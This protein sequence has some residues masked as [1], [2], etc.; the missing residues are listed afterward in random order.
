MKKAVVF[1]GQFP[2]KL[3]GH[4][5]L[6]IGVKFESFFQY[7]NI[8]QF[9]HCIIN[10]KLFYFGKGG[11]QTIILLLDYFSVMNVQ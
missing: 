1:V 7:G 11:R 8:R 6:E 10:A 5:K 3:D 2:L 4:F 9:F